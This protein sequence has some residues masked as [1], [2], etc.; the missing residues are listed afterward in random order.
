MSRSELTSCINKEISKE[1]NRDYASKIS[2]EYLQY[3]FDQSDYTKSKLR[4]LVKK[5][6]VKTILGYLS[7]T[8]YPEEYFH[9]SLGHNVGEKTLT[10]MLDN[11]GGIYPPDLE[12][13]NIIKDPEFWSNDETEEEWSLRDKY[14]GLIFF[15]WLSIMWMEIEG[16][17]SKIVV[18]T[19]ENNSVT[20]FYLND[21]QFDLNSKFCLE[22]DWFKIIESYNVEKI[23]I[24]QLLENI[25]MIYGR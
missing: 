10:P 14:H 2:K 9:M 23:E 19:T 15:A 6:N 25:K 21:F 24:E 16:Y 3:Y 4:Q 12:I 8:G 7:K 1:S 22:P 18:K 5:Y 11:G 17:K 13:G 20:S